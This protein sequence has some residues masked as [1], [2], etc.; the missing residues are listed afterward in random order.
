MA[1]QDKQQIGDGSDNIGQAAQK[2]AEAAKQVSQAAAEK[3]A[4]AG[5][6]ATSTAAGASVAA[7]AQG[8]SGGSRCCRRYGC[9]WSRWGRTCRGMGHASYPV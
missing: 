7:A 9:G 2:T 6:E 5:A 1:E 3:A 8:R 4:V